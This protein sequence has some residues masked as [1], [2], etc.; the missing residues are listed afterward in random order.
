MNNKL[1]VVGLTA[2]L[3][4]AIACS[5]QATP[6]NNRPNTGSINV[7][8]EVAGM[9]LIDGAE[10][11]KRIKAQGTMLID[12]IETGLTETAIQL[13]DGV[14]VKAAEMVLVKA[15][16]TAAV[17]ITFS[18]NTQQEVVPYVTEAEPVKQTEATVPTT[19]VESS[20]QE[21]KVTPVSTVT[22]SVTIPTA[23]P[24][25]QVQAVPVQNLAQSDFVLRGSVLVEYRG[26]AEIV[27]VPANLGITE[28]GDNVFSRNTIREVII[29]EGVIK[30]GKSFE[31]NDQLTKV[32]LPSS[33]TTI[34]D[35]S[36]GLCTALTSIAIPSRVTSIGHLAFCGCVSLT[37]VTIPSGVT[38][39]NLATFA[40]CYTLTDI[41]IPASV[42]Y[43]EKRAFMNCESLTSV[44]IPSTRFTSVGEEAFIGCS[45]LESVYFD[46]DL[47]G[48]ITFNH[49]SFPNGVMIHYTD[50]SPFMPMSIARTYIAPFKPLEIPSLPP[51]K[52]EFKSQE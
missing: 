16:E 25:V 24:Q 19:V 21:T 44:K 41:T 10:T 40:E 34:G 27:N 15:G 47:N 23:Q 7:S 36:F 31:R 48:K 3:L 11:G 38:K 30:I 14:I 9:V 42:T 50:N 4:V 39:I 5:K 29:P 52:L 46:Y 18:L 45:S 37:S 35:S 1:R 8:S 51:V 26:N 2:L 32:T 33:L 22:A 13:D 20:R 12:N 28:I 43:I 6:T 17:H 49:P